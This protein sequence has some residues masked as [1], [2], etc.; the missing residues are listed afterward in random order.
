MLVKKIVPLSAEKQRAVDLFDGLIVKVEKFAIDFSFIQED[1]RELLGI[2]DS[3]LHVKQPSRKAMLKKIF[4]DTT[5][6]SA[7]YDLG[8]QFYVE[9]VIGF[10]G[11]FQSSLLELYHGANE[12][13]WVEIADFADE[14][15]QGKK[16]PTAKIVKDAIQRF[17]SGDDDEEILPDNFSE[18]EAK[19]KKSK[20][21]VKSSSEDDEELDGN[22]KSDRIVTRELNKL[23]KLSMAE[24][25]ITLNTLKQFVTVDKPT[26]IAINLRYLVN[27][28]RYKFVVK[29]LEKE[30]KR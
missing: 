15:K 11:W 16:R 9:S 27:D 20:A 1:V 5:A 7:L 17:Y 23:K 3:H 24:K 2:K 29:K 10:R 30:L 21:S 22:S 18:E 25:R 14:A 28:D 4:N 19:S 13:D 8:N 26:Q 12:D 6:D